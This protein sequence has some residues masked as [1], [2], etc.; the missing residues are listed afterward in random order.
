M[1]DNDFEGLCAICGVDIDDVDFIDED[2][3]NVYRTEEFIV[4]QNI[5]FCGDGLG[6]TRILSEDTF[7]CRTKFRDMLY[8]KI[9]LNDGKRIHSAMYVRTYIE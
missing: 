4:S 9:F 5:H 1:I 3:T 7:Y 8:D 2:T 6:S